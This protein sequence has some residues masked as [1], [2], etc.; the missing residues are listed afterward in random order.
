MAPTY[1]SLTIRGA[2]KSQQDVCS[3]RAFDV[4]GLGSLL[5]VL[6]AD[7]HGEDDGGKIADIATSFI[8]RNVASTIKL[9]ADSI[10]LSSFAGAQNA[11]EKAN[12][13]GGTTATLV[14]VTKGSLAI[15]YCG[16]S[17][18]RLVFKSGKLHT[19]T[20]PHQYGVHRGE[21]VR[22]KKRGVLI[23][24]FPESPQIPDPPRGYVT[25]ESGARIA[26]TRALGDQ[27]FSPSGIV[28][29]EPELVRRTLAKTH[30]FL[31]VASDGFWGLFTRGW[32]R[33]QLER[34]LAVAQNADGALAAI[35][36]L[37]AERFVG[38][39]LTVVIVDLAEFIS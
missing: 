23:T 10:F 18:A 15:A 12:L 2:R 38:D 39:N 35:K 16:D 24:P 27:D 8:V 20:I 11:I 5:I 1:V 31:V 4:D 37:I 22:L 29:S 9:S 3:V 21:T 33:H 30:R 6:V 32:R 17:E 14:V 28:L 34:V 13:C 36:T 25:F 26:L 19:L 7:G